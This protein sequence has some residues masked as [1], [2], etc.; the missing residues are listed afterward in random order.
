[1][2]RR[3]SRSSGVIVFIGTGF[4]AAAIVAVAC[5]WVTLTS[6]SVQAADPNNI[7][8]DFSA[9]WCGPCQ[10]MSPIVSRL[11]RRGFPVRQVDIDREGE[12]ARRF[13]VESIPCFVL[14][15]NGREVSRITGATDENKLI[16][17]MNMLPKQS[18][19]A[20]LADQS[21]RKNG[22]LTLPVKP[23]SKS[24]DEKKPFLKLPNLFSKNGE[25]KLTPTDT[26]ET[27]RSQSPGP[28]PR[29]GK[30]SRESL[31]ASVR[32]RVKNGDH[33]HLG[34]GTVIDSQPGR[35]VILTC[36][37]ILR[38]LNKNAV[39]EVDVFPG[40]KSEPQTTVAQILKFDLESDVGLLSI[41][42]Q[43]RL[44]TVRLATNGLPAVEE[45]V[46]S[47]GCGGGS[48]PA[49]EEHL[50]K[51]I[52]SCVGPDNLECTGVPQQ[53]R[54]GGGLFQGSELI[55]VCILADPKFKRGI[56]S[57]MKPVI[58]LLDKAKLGHLAGSSSP[59]DDL[60]AEEGSPGNNGSLG[61]PLGIDDGAPFDSDDSVARVLEASTRQPAGVQTASVA[62]DY[63]GAEIVCIVRPKNKGAMS[64]VVIVNQ[65]ST[66]FVAD[67][68]HESGG[69]HRTDAAATV[70]HER[71]ERSSG[72][73]TSALPKKM[74]AIESPIRPAT[75]STNR[76]K[77]DPIETAF[78]PKPYRRNRSQTSSD[79]E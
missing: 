2:Q 15:A 62:G 18:S 34:S 49:V 41:P 33:V 12:L 72:G 3:N 28:G 69:S 71:T 79:K 64:R 55:G 13:H 29:S 25:A 45:R 51:A 77:D 20:E 5:S 48:R 17:L 8:L 44:A 23:G 1:M 6:V 50:V 40:G 63:I 39:V 36:G 30:A 9:K 42:C 57:G 7:L 31:V 66:R 76:R 56:Y 35:A 26:P 19:D 38:D 54:S 32:I 68:L 59:N 52:N 37:H 58:Q 14:V 60:V 21:P 74:A 22:P 78:E 11:E 24:A 61:S 46:F 4:A 75:V 47:I 70:G 73:Q 43:Q 27:I 65:A 53:G 67:L 10:Q 16:S